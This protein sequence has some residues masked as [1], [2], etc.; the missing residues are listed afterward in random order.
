MNLY[1][2]LFL[3]AFISINSLNAQVLKTTE[4]NGNLILEDIPPIPQQLKDDLRKFQNV[5]QGLLEVLMLLVSNYT[6]Q[7]DLEMLANFI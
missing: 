1:I 3:L 4:N 7:Q 6:F 5:D 2:K